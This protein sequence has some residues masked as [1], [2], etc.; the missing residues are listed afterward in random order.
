MHESDPASI[1][2][3]ALIQNSI[4]AKKAGMMPGGGPQQQ[5][6]QNQRSPIDGMRRDHM[7]PHQQQHSSPILNNNNGL[8]VHHMPM[9]RPPP[10]M[11]PPGHYPM[12]MGM[13][14][15]MGMPMGMSI[16]SDNLVRVPLS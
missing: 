9:Q 16:V 2:L 15:G 8:S 1:Q 4:M 10:G 7:H 11:P 5:Q 14:P 3:Q 12:P 13:H 6:L